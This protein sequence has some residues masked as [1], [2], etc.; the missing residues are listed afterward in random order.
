MSVA[1]GN[2]HISPTWDSLTNRLQMIPTRR[3]CWQISQIVPFPYSGAKFDTRT[4]FDDITRE[5]L[6]RLYQNH[7]RR[8]TSRGGRSGSRAS[9]EQTA[10]EGAQNIV[11]VEEVAQPQHLV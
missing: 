7:G 5:L 10:A 3:R 9:I 2:E 6:T 8:I 1:Q 11:E 4:A